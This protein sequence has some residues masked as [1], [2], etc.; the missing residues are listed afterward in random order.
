MNESEP[1]RRGRP[2]KGTERDSRTLIADAAA[3]EFAEHGYDGTSLRAIARKAGVDSALVHHYFSDKAGLFAAVVDLPVRPDRVLKTALDAPGDQLGDSI[4]RTVITAWERPD[5]R[6]RV[7][8][9]AKRT[10]GGSFGGVVVKE[11]LLREIMRAIARRLH[12]PDAQLRAQLAASQLVGVLVL[13]YVLEVEPLAS[14]PADAV[15]ADIAPV[16]QWHLTG[17]PLD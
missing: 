9:M 16:L 12:G 15:I 4:A 11:F 17:R 1:R 2:R 7:V 5:V 8:A 10:F 13:R 3:T 14:Q 6:P